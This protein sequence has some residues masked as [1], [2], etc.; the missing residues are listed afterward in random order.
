MKV[1]NKVLYMNKKEAG[2]F[3]HIS[4]LPSPY[5]IGTFGKIAFD[6]VDFLKKSKMKVWQ[7]LPLNVTS[8]GDSPY[9]S[10]SNYGFNYNFIDLD[11]LIE[12]GLL[13]KK[14]V[15]NIDFGEDEK[16]VNYKKIFDNRINVLKIAFNNFK[17]D[18]GFIDFLNTN[19]DARDFSFFMTIKELN[20]HLPWFKWKRKYRKYSSFLE[21]KIINKHKQ[22]FEFYMW[23]Q[24]EFINQYTKLKEYANKNGIKIMGDLPIYLA[25]DS[26]ECY[27]YPKMFQF[28]KKNRPTSVAGCPPDY[29]SATGQLWGNPL[30]D[31]EYHKQTN[32]SWWNDRINNALKLYDLIRIDHFRGFSAYYSIKYKAKDAI[33][34][35]WINGPGFDLFKDKLNYPIVAEDLGTLDEAFYK[36]MDKTG[37]PGMKISMKGVEYLDPSNPWRPRNYNDK[38]YA[39]TS[40]HDTETTLQ[41]IN[42]MS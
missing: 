13:D 27:K 21:E 40:I 39:Y 5:G 42:S 31:W 32:Y 18:D 26:V 23:T 19:I 38:C 22:L 37:Y 24:Y 9:Q 35:K 17:Y 30:Y 3:M 15:F 14:D 11:I 8:Y 20:N 29:Y 1:A 28:D 16:R 12:K 6:F 2:I 41:Y 36:F 7:I 10:P 34:G 33:N 25:Y 4:S